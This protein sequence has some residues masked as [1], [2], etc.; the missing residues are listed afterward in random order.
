M[1]SMI[2]FIFT[3]GS[4]LAADTLKYAGEIADDAGNPLNGEYLMTFSLYDDPQGYIIWEE[5]QDV[6]V[7]DG[8]YEVVLGSNNPLSLPE[9]KEYYLEVTL[10]GS[11]E[12]AAQDVVTPAGKKPKKFKKP[13]QI[14]DW[15]FVG[16]TSHTPNAK[17]EVNPDEIEDN[18]DEFVVDSD[19]NVGIGTTSP[20][21]KLDVAGKLRSENARAQ[22]QL[23]NMVET[24]STD[25]VDLLS[26]TVTTGDNALL[27][28]FS[29]SSMQGVGTK[30]RVHFRIVLDGT[31]V[32]GATEEFHN[33]GWETRA[34]PINYLAVSPGAGV[35]TATVQWKIDTG[36]HARIN[37]RQPNWSWQTTQLIAIELMN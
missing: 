36:T 34:T 15:L 10:G 31:Q 4:A 24:S 27:I 29:P 20:E 16:S 2:I 33:N 18:G 30:C 23:T 21:A 5:T 32:A 28:I 1:L 35:H 9:D 22:T 14:T 8:H 6:I 13:V 17:F 3:A 19:G 11:P 37:W 7:Q 12:L 25:W 26:V